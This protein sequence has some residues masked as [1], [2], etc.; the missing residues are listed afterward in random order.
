MQRRGDD[1]P[2]VFTDSG[3]AERSPSTKHAEPGGALPAGIARRTGVVFVHG[4]GTQAP[5]ETFLDWSGPMV[6]LLTEWRAAEEAAAGSEGAQ[7]DDRIDDPVWRAELTFNA[8]SPPYLELSIPAHAG[9]PGTTWVITEAW[10]AS[11]L[12]PPNLG[13]TIDYLRRRMAT[14]VSGI[15][16]GYR[17]RSPRLVELAQ[18]TDVIGEGL[19]PLDWRLAEELDRVQSLAF[20]ARP[21]GWLVGGSGVVA[22][23]GYDVLR[24]I[25]IPVVRDFAVR[26][27]I[28]SFLIGSATC[29]SCS[30]SRSNRPT[31]AHGSPARS[32]G[33][34]MMGATRS[35]WSPTPVAHW[36][37][38]RRCSTRHTRTSASTS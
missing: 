3:A 31:C 6:E 32:N 4:I 24:R 28:D 9:M 23:A 17:D 37:A 25:P 10:W 26:R 19:P 34:S 36:S 16:A 8:A 12:R 33:S 38:S 35:W 15:A 5:S 18:A 27:M 14:V 13:R 2:T 21:L 7:D 11:D 20:G 1:Q 22:L 29:R 30:T